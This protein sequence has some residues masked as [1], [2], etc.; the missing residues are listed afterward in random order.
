MLLILYET[1]V[2]TGVECN[3]FG[4]KE[5]LTILNASWNGNVLDTCIGNLKTCKSA[6][7]G[8]GV[9]MLTRSV[10]AQSCAGRVS[11]SVKA[12]TKSR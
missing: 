12:M 7:S 9:E 2:C 8:L 4:A 3:E 1:R 5:I 10:V 11:A 6:S